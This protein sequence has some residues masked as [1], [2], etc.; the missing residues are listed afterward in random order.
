VTDHYPTGPPQWNPSLEAWPGGPHPGAIAMM[1]D[2]KRQREEDESAAQV[3]RKRTTN[4]LLL[5]R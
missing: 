4:H 2:E 3:A 1:F 5:L